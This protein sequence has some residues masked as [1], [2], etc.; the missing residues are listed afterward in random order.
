MFGFLVHRSE[1][2]HVI[3][4]II[5]PALCTAGTPSA[6]RAVCGPHEGML[7]C[8]VTPKPIIAPKTDPFPHE[9][10]GL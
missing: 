2:I 6:V 9:S 1:S 3:Y 4:C 8:Q 7:S 5:S 10:V